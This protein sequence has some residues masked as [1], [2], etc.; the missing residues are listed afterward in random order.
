ML[1]LAPDDLSARR[2]ICDRRVRFNCSPRDFDAFVEV[3]G[4]LK[5]LSSTLVNAEAAIRSGC[6][7][8]QS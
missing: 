6:Q 3:I 1:T 7:T 8:H 4:Y 5:P 2:S